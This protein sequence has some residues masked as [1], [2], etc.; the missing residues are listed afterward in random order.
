MK[1]S[2]GARILK[3]TS[4]SSPGGF[5][6]IS[7]AGNMVMDRMKA[8]TMPMPATMPSSATPV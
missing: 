5:S 6:T 8:I 4:S 7:R 1:V 2:S 3:P